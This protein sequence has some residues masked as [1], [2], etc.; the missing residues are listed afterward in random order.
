MKA[1]SSVPSVISD[2]YEKKEDDVAIR[3]S[4]FP[5][6]GV[7]ERWNSSANKERRTVGEGIEDRKRGASRIKQ[8]KS[9]QLRSRQINFFL[10]FLPFSLLVCMPS[11][12]EKETH[13]D[14]THKTGLETDHRCSQV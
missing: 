3:Y 12:K 6:G 9:G 13:A 7:V 10:S 5:T 4:L 11:G 1:S 14:T 2:V 8:D